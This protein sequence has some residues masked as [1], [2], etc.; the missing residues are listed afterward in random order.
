[1]KE[2]KHQYL[3]GFTSSNKERQNTKHVSF[4]EQKL[5]LKKIN[6]LSNQMKMQKEK[7]KISQKIKQEF[8]DTLK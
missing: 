5:L 3:L 4:Q 1:M 7:M 2:K 6:A 8:D